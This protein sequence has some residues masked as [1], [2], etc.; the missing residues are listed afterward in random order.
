MLGK[1]KKFKPFTHNVDYD[2]TSPYDYPNTNRLV[3]KQQEASLKFLHMLPQLQIK[4]SYIDTDFSSSSRSDR[5]NSDYVKL[6]DENGNIIAIAGNNVEP[7]TSAQISNNPN[8][9]NP[10]WTNTPNFLDNEGYTPVIDAKKIT[11][12]FIN[13]PL[14]RNSQNTEGSNSLDIDIF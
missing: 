12:E 11:I 8:A 7:G 14:Q 5:R 3:I 13:G 9:W 6:T 4:F 1:K 2:V 10:T